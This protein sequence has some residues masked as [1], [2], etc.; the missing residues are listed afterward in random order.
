MKV[1]NSHICILSC[2]VNLS[3]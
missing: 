3:Y 1:L 2:F